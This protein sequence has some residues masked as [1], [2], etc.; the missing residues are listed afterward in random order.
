MNPTNVHENDRSPQPRQRCCRRR[1]RLL[2]T[3]AC[4]PRRPTAKSSTPEVKM[5]TTRGVI[6]LQ[7]FPK[8]APISCAN[9]IKLVNKGLLQRPVLPPRHRPG[10]ARWQQHR[11]HHPGR[12][13]GRQRQR[14]TGIYDQRR[15][16]RSNGVEQPA[17]CTMPARSRW[18]ALMAPTPRAR[19]F[20]ICTTPCHDLDGNYAVFGKV[21]SGP[22]QSPRKIAAG[23]QDDQGDDGP[24]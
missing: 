13:S 22:G 24:E 19:Q 8:N 11:P 18:R 12:R 1:R 7:L 17:Q 6:V 15:V 21:I 14:R 23:R 16:S 20:Y 3:Q 2:L 4:A 9:F 5:V 10:L